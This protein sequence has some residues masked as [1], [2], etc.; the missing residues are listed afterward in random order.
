MSLAAAVESKVGAISVLSTLPIL[1]VVIFADTEGA[2]TTAD[3]DSVV[4]LRGVVSVTD[5]AG[6]GTVVEATNAAS[7]EGTTDVMFAAVAI[8]AALKGVNVG[9]VLVIPGVVGD[10]LVELAVDATAGEVAAG[11]GIG[12]SRECPC[13]VDPGSG[14]K[15]RKMKC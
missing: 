11:P 12:K 2:V 7:V 9:I 3:V 14:A 5:I 1:G 4:A 10:A 6:V 15:I 13:L 8:G